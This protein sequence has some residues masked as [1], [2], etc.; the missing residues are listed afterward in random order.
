MNTKSKKGE[1]EAETWEKG[2]WRTVRGKKD[3]LLE[4]DKR[5]NINRFGL[6]AD[7]FPVLKLARSGMKPLGGGR[8]SFNVGAVLRDPGATT[9]IFRGGTW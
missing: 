3:S 1:S 2:D 8:S 6:S 4:G 9:G 5:T 7:Y